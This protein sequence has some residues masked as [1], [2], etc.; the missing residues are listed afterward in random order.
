MTWAPNTGFSG[1]SAPN[2]LLRKALV[3]GPLLALTACATRPEPKIV[4][5]FESKPTAV[6]CIDP[7][8]RGEPTYPV[9]DATLKAAPGPDV[10]LQQLGA[11]YLLMKQRLSELEPAV[12][13]CR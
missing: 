4:T 10:R 9:T 11:I 3:V 13:N 12:R 5:Q 7:R 8:L 1:L 6:S 2:P